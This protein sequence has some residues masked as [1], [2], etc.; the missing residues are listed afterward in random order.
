MNGRWREKRTEGEYKCTVLGEVEGR[1]G[2]TF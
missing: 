2:L 1:E